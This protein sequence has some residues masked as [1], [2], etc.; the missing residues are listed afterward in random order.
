MTRQDTASVLYPPTV[1]RLLL[2]VNDAVAR[3][4]HAH[5]RGAVIDGAGITYCNSVKGEIE[6]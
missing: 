4:L 6:S 2:W 3:S 5:R 1:D